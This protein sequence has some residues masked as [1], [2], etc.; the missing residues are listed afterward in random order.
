MF[1]A[2]GKHQQRFRFEVHFFVQHQIAQL[3]AQRR[4]ARFARAH[5][6][7]AALLDVVADEAI[8]VDL[9]AP[10]MPSKVMNLPVVSHCLSLILLTARLWS[11]RLSENWLVPLP[12]ETKYRAAVLAGASAA[13]SDCTPGKAIGVGG[14]PAR[15]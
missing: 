6:R 1:A 5:Q 13:V 8:C 15:V 14:R 10:S 3:F 11:F 7:Y 4:A 12:L 9:P 2:A